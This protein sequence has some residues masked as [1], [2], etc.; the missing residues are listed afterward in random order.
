MCNDNLL[1]NELTLEELQ[2]YTLSNTNER[3]PTFEEVLS[4]VDGKV[5]ILVEY[6]ADLPGTECSCFCAETN[7]ILMEYNGEYAIESF[8]YLVLGWYKKYM[9]NILRGQLSMGMQ[10]YE[11]ALGK[12]KAKQLSMKNRRMVTHLLCNYIGR[13]HFI[14]YRWQDIKLPVKIN[15]FLGAKIACWTVVDK[16]DSQRL[17]TK[18]DSIIFEKFL[19]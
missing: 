3:I 4:L 8:N 19:A 14:S 12:E 9:P 13:P 2:N 15:K 1:V 6:K 18:Y 5:P 7:K 17:M 16:E 10:C 11:V